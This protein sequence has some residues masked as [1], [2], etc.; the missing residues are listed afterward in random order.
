MKKKETAP[1]ATPAGKISGT[2]AVIAEIVREPDG[3]NGHFH[4]KGFVVVRTPEGIKFCKEED[5][6][7]PI[8]WRTLACNLRNFIGQLNG[9]PGIALVRAASDPNAPS[10]EMDKEFKGFR[11]FQNSG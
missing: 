6:G 7:F 9:G 3:A 1:A 11:Q 5:L 2:A 10:P 4:P 8:R